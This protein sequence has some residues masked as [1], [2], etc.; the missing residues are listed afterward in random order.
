[1]GSWK[2]WLPVWTGL[3]KLGL[4]EWGSQALETVKVLSKIRLKAF[5][6]TKARRTIAISFTIL[7]NLRDLRDLRDLRV[8][9]GDVFNQA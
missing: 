7:K 5:F 9:G 8:F 6:T 2:L 1:M 3:G 4:P